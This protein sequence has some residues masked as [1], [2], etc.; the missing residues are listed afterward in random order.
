MARFAGGTVEPDNG[1][2]AGCV[3][4]L[5]LLEVVDLDEGIGRYPM[6][7]ALE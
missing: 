3:E 4:L 5:F 7:H 1:E 2:I 6:P